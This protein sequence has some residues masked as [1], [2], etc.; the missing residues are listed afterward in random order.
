VQ[1]L[2]SV[3]DAGEARGAGAVGADIIDAKEPALGALAPVPPATLAAIADALPPGARLSV[4]LGEPAD[5]DALA[6]SLAARAEVVRGR[7]VFLKFVPPTLDVGA[8][9]A[10]VAC[11]R[12]AA[13][14]AQVIV[15]G[16]ADRLAAT[17]LG[18]LAQAAAEAGADG[19]LLDT[20]A[21]GV[22]LLVRLAVPE[23]EGFVAA[24]HARGLLVALAGS[25][26]LEDLP[27]IAALGADV[28]GVRGA[29]CDGDRAGRLS[30]PRVRRLLQAAR[31][32]VLPVPAAPA[33]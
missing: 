24:A 12:H 18:R 26:A 14:G 3:R 33:S 5:V 32:A 27:R 9:S 31:A 7:P 4:A 29:A 19:V 1:L 8:L 30:A 16:Y 28:A 21:K 11:A 20:A 2:V 25:L 22:S 23:L 10:M 17:G 15:A 13:P 6:A